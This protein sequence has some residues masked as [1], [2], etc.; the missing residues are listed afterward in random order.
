MAAPRY[1]PSSLLRRL[2]LVWSRHPRARARDAARRH[3]R[4]GYDRDRDHDRDRDRRRPEPERRAAAWRR[5]APQDVAQLREVAVAAGWRRR[6]DGH[7]APA[8][9]VVVVWVR[10][11]NF[12]YFTL[13]SP[14]PANRAPAPPVVLASW[15]SR[16]KEFPLPAYS[17]ARG[18][19]IS[20]RKKNSATRDRVAWV[21]ALG[22]GLVRGAQCQ[23]AS[24]S[25]FTKAARRR[26][27]ADARRAH[28]KTRTGGVP[29]PTWP[30]LRAALRAITSRS[31]THGLT[32]GFGAKVAWNGRSSSAMGRCRQAPLWWSSRTK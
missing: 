20:R 14:A 21:T 23:V 17:R 32:F 28:H 15:P 22:H 16:T 26:R 29:R 31:E 12:F 18:S 3:T 7:L 6:R 4:G 19:E 30:T 5:R 13:C 1:P 2:S 10:S 9:H 25:P 27:P 11:S 24:F 8:V